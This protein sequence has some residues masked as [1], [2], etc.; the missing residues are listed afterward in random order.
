[1]HKVLEEHETKCTFCPDCRTNCQHCDILITNKELEGHKVGCKEEMEK[2]RELQK[3][4][5]EGDLLIPQG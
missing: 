1:M 4:M 2:R 3:E 5:G